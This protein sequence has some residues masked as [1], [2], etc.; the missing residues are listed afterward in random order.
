MTVCV[1]VWSGG[2]PLPFFKECHLQPKT[3]AVGWSNCVT[4][5]VANDGETKATNPSWPGPGPIPSFSFPLFHVVSFRFVWFRSNQSNLQ[6]YPERFH[7]NWLV[8]GGQGNH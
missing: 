8:Y 2:E 5:M 1:W 4:C 6:M 7:R 3:N